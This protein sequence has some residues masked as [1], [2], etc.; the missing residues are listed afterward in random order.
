MEP[1]RPLITRDG[2]LFCAAL[3]LAATPPL[4]A[5][6][7]AR[8]QDDTYRRLAEEAARAM[9]ERRPAD[10]LVVF[11]EMHALAPSARTFW[12][13]GRVHYEL[14]QYVIALDYL[15][16]ALTDPR[17]PLEAAQ[18]EEVV[19]LQ[20]RAEA[21]TGVLALSVAP[22][23]AT[24]LL[25]DVEVART[26]DARVPGLLSRS[27]R[28]QI[29][30]GVQT[31]SLA[32]ELRLDPGDHVVR[33]ERAGREPA[34]RRVQIR[35]GERASAAVLDLATEETRR[36]DTALG[37]LVIPSTGGLGVSVPSDARIVVE[38]AAGETR[39]LTVHLQ[40]LAIA[41]APGPIGPPERLC[42]APCEARHALG[43]YAAL[44]SLPGEETLLSAPGVV[45]VVSDTLFTV[46]LHDETPTRVAGW[47]AT[48]LILGYGLVGTVLGAAALAVDDGDELR[49]ALSGSAPGV[50]LGTGIPAIVLG[51]L[52]LPFALAPDWA[53]VR[54]SPLR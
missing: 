4:A 12:S 36:F 19:A 13:L 35:P 21:L 34:V 52:G 53:E 1:R 49:V 7:R 20:A 31:S 24:I 22:A 30:D 33:I 51:L 8:A 23:D 39:A 37:A 18:R 40:P 45:P 29:V 50:L 47:I 28:V 25:D 46:S 44:V 54:V 17:R 48:G 42:T 3:F 26:A 43:S 14:G 41:G 9:A 2:A 16:Q 6:P 10:A 11:R 5:T 38:P 27:Q 15:G 32:L